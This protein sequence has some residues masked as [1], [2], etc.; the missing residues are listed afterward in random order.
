MRHEGASEERTPEAASMSS[1]SIASVPQAAAPEARV[2]VPELS[3][4]VREHAQFVARV[5]RRLGV[6]RADLDDVVQDTFLVVQRR[7]HTFEG[8]GSVRSWMY[9]VALRVASDYRA[10]PRHRRELLSAE[11]PE[12]VTLGAPQEAELERQRAWAMLEMLLSGL[13]P[14]QRQV[15]VLYE[16]EELNMREV[17]ELLG[18]PQQT[19]YTRLHSAR[20]HV[21]EARKRLQARGQL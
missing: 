6:R 14:E 16:L 1:V 19:A 3:A 12:L 10:K 18:C 5:L 13:S 9:A 2:E 4:L 8:R 7:L 20:K 15:F 21:Q 17:A 11:P